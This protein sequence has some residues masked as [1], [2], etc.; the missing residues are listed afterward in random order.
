MDAHAPDGQLQVRLREKADTSCPLAPSARGWAGPGLEAFHGHYIF[1][2]N[3]VVFGRGE[4]SLT[5][6]ILRKLEAELHIG[7]RVITTYPLALSGGRSQ[8]YTVP[9]EAR[10][11]SYC[12]HGVLE[13][14][15]EVC[16]VEAVMSTI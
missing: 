16:A 8:T 12:S 5:S 15:Y 3:N 7:T 4:G 10:V 9:A 13:R 11:P 14:V 6:R 2:I 1:D